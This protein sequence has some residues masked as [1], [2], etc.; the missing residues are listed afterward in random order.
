MHFWWRWVCSRVPP[1]HSLFSELSSRNINRVIKAA[2]SKLGLPYAQSHTSHGF[3]L[4]AAQELKERGSQWTAVAGI[5]GWRSLASRGYVGTTA[6]ISRAMARLLIE[7]FD[8][9]SSDE[10]QV[11]FF[12]WGTPLH[13]FSRRAMGVWGFRARRFRG[14]VA[15]SFFGVMDVS[16]L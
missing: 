12:G 2:F 15:I 13:R 7:D 14:L 11:L 6:D 16:F 4:G 10:E 5:G 9:A 3:R 1:G 8:P